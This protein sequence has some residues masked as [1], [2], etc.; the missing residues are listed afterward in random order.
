MDFGRKNST[1]VTEHSST[2]CD[3]EFFIQLG[4]SGRPHLEFHS[5]YPSAVLLRIWICF[6]GRTYFFCET[7]FSFLA[8]LQLNIN[9]PLRQESVMSGVSC[10]TI[11]QA[12]PLHFCILQAIKTW[13][14]MRPGNEATELSLTTK[15]QQSRGPDLLH[16]MQRC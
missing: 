6:T 7:C 11:P 4:T 16:S 8:S 10:I 5:C 12:F 13:R 3:F 14:C 2:H 9:K 1:I 15:C